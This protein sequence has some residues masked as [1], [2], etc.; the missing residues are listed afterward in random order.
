MHTRL[1]RR[2]G[3]RCYVDGQC[4]LRRKW[5]S[6]RLCR[7]LCRS[8]WLTTRCFSSTILLHL[9]LL[10]T[11]QKQKIHTQVP[12]EGEKFIK[13]PFKWP[14]YV[15]LLS[16]PRCAFFSSRS[17]RQTRSILEW[18]NSRSRTIPGRTRRQRGRWWPT[19]TKWLS[20][21]WRLQVL[22]KSVVELSNNSLGMSC[23]Q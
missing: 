15:S 14:T 1:I 16:C 5:M 11:K 21:L 8:I 18:W 4:H 20:P 6:K 17:V 9:T 19:I 12:N 3:G 10:H 13:L 22:R 23:I 2:A 7:P